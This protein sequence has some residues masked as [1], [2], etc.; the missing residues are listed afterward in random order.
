MIAITIIAV[1]C[2]AAIAVLVAFVIFSI[3]SKTWPSVEGKIVSIE[4]KKESFP[5]KQIGGP[6]VT[7]TYTPIIKYQYV[8]CGKSYFGTRIRFGL[9]NKA[10]TDAKSVDEAITSGAIG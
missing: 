10:F 5:T 7:F 8:V 6:I 3:T 4:L 2:L 9:R 1:L